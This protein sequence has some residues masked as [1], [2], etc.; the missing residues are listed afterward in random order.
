MPQ[1]AV[2][3]NEKNTDERGRGETLPPFYREGD[4]NDEQRQHEDRSW[5]GEALVQDRAISQAA[6]SGLPARFDGLEDLGHREGSRASLQEPEFAGG[7]EHD[8]CLPQAFRIRG[9]GGRVGIEPV[10]CSIADTPARPGYRRC[11]GGVERFH[12]TPVWAG[13][14]DTD[15]L[16]APRFRVD[17][18]SVVEGVVSVVPERSPVE[19]DAFFRVLETVELAI[20]AEKHGFVQ[21]ERKPRERDGGEQHRERDAKQRDPSGLEGRDLAGSS[22]NGKTQKCSDGA[23]GGD[24]V[25]EIQ[26]WDSNQQV[27]EC[28]ACGVAVLDDVVEIHEHLDDSHQNESD[29]Q[30][31]CE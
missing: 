4:G 21:H 31:E 8:L 6:P 19:H 28:S 7:Y 24:D 9:D 26:G 2:A 18:P 25:A 15:I 17:F 5:L 30:S 20:D 13:L 16:H 12:E 3:G 23:G 10:A 1:G 11:L 29:D 14:V 27:C 22:G